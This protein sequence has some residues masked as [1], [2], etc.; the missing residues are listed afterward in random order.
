MK[1]S[2]DEKK[3]FKKPF[4]NGANQAD[5]EQVE[6]RIHELLDLRQPLLSDVIIREHVSQCDACAELVIDFGALNDSLSQVPLATL[7]RL[8]GLQSV[9]TQ[10]GIGRPHPLSFIASIACLMLVLLTSGVW[11]S[12]NQTPDIRSVAVSD[13][14]SPIVTEYVS[15]GPLQLATAA[16]AETNAIPHMSAPSDFLNAVSFEKLSGGVEPLQDYIDITAE[17]PGIRPVS[18]S[19]HATF[20]LLRFFAEQSAVPQDTKPGTAPDLGCY[21]GPFVQFCQV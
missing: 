21:D 12:T 16:P 10:T 4:S 9:E 2:Q 13:T 15:T 1:E 11:F 14:E 19:F 7:N 8:S 20:H 18:Q 17:L 3:P 6:S 5:C